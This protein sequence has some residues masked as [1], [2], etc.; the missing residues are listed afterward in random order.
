L[1]AVALRAA[2]A[3]HVSDGDSGDES[4]GEGSGYED[5]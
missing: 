5:D 2:L 1:H 4:I 3:G